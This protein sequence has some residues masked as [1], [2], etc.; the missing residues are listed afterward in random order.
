MASSPQE[1]TAT[2]MGGIVKTNNRDSWFVD[3]PRSTKK[4]PRATVR[5]QNPGCGGL[6]GG[7]LCAFQFLPS[8]ERASIVRWRTGRFLPGQLISCT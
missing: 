7:G 6:T 8:K 5:N 2:P 1:C 3:D 4:R